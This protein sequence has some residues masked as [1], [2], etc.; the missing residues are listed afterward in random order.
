V[1][2]IRLNTALSFSTW[3][4]LPLL[5]LGLGIGP[6]A[7]ELSADDVGVY[8]KSIKPLLT[9]HC[10]ACHA[11][12]AKAKRVRLDR[13]A[14]EFAGEPGAHWS[15][16]LEKLRAGEMPPKAD[17]QPSAAEQKRLQEWIGDNLR[18]AGEAQ[19]KAQGRV[20]LRRLN[21]VEYQNTVRDLLSIDTQLSEML[22][23]DN[24]VDGFDNSA[25]GLS[26]ST[27]L[28]RRYLE[29]A[30]AALEA[31]MV[32]GP[33]PESTKKRFTSF[34][35]DRPPDA[36]S[37]SAAAYRMPDASVFFLDR[38]I[39]HTFGGQDVLPRIP[40]DFPLAL[41]VGG[42]YRFTVS[43]YAYQATEPV[44]LGIYT[45][46]RSIPGARPILVGH[47]DLKPGAPQILEFTHR[48]KPFEV[49]CMSSEGLGGEIV[50]L[51]KKNKKFPTAEEYKGPGAAVQWIEM[52][53]PL[54]QT[55]PPES[56]RRLFGDLPLVPLPKEKGKTTIAHVV[57]STEPEADAERLL[58]KFATQAYRTPAIDKEL[59]PILT[60]VR[61]QLKDGTSFQDALMIGYKAVLCSP[62]FLY[63]REE[64]G[65]LTDYALASRLSY[66][67]WSS[68]PDHELFDLA[69]K[70][71]L[72]DPA[73][74]WKQT[75][76]LLRDPKAKALTENFVGQWLGLRQIEDTLPDEKL[77]PEFDEL[78]Q[79][80]MPKE[81]TFF[82]DEILKHDLSV[83]NFI[84]SEFSMLNGRLA[85]HYGILGVEGGEFRKVT[86]PPES[87]RGGV[88]AHASIL[89]VS[90][91]GTT[92]SPVVRGAWVLRNIVGRPPSPP[93]ADVPA[94]EPDLK[95]ATTI[96][97][98]LDKHR[99]KGCAECHVKIDPLGFALERFDVIGGR[100]EFYRSM[101]KGPAVDVQVRGKPVNYRKGPAVD[102]TGEMGDGKKYT[103]FA[104][105]KRL[106]LEDKD[107]IARCLTEKL[108]AYGT[109]RG[110]RAGDSAAV[111][112]IV[113]ADRAKNYGLRSL[114]HEVVQS[115]V[116]LNR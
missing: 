17:P 3:I 32:R 112:A 25:E 107:Q 43:G 60:L 28:M 87:D 113:A 40:K 88:L 24:A 94:V 69:A 73:E 103:T 86:L 38:E 111:E 31:A 75:E 67:L 23:E 18:L 74:L 64:P 4:K 104:E 100:Q 105:F 110:T 16:V 81:T 61:S 92:T 50:A 11:E 15:M 14:P 34:S 93:P 97:Q 106:L 44:T 89:R 99:V 85:R 90:A 59:K 65:K 1:N 29:A 49:I 71:K 53:G 8:E 54:N 48:L 58:R 33:Q 76:R 72:S 109:G 96:R 68:M 39:E 102:A 108:L 36:S 37:N 13:L 116:F 45:I 27:V 63:L 6:A 101:G 46:N 51:W 115:P 77:Y 47:F 10:F 66:F 82:F 7:R 80:A 114:V 91:N 78:L 79:H 95:G 70:N 5:L 56:H 21:R 42:R 22:P 62:Y 19:Q 84:D 12:N 26:V 2:C 9:K 30:D 98:L 83:H 55:W 41:K 57:K 52:E 20:P 35:Y